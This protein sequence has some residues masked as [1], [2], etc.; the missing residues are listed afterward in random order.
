MDRVDNH[1]RYNDNLIEFA[2][3]YRFRPIV[4][5][6]YQPQSKGRVERSIRYIRSSFLEG[7]SLSSREQLNQE[8][9][10]WC[11]SYAKS[12]PWREDPK[13]TVGEALDEERSSFI[14]RPEMELSLPRIIALNADVHGWVS[15]ESNK[16]SV[17][18]LL[19][20]KSLSLYAYIDKVELWQGQ[21]K[22]ASHRRSWAL[23]TE[24]LDAS[25]R[26]NLPKANSRSRVS[27][28]LAAILADFPRLQELIYLY[29]DQQRDNR[30]L[31]KFVEE[32]RDVHGI[33]LTE[34]LI[35]IVRLE[36]LVDLT[37]IRIKLMEILKSTSAQENLSTII[38][39]NPAARD[40]QIRSHSLDIYDNL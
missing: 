22:V 16:Y 38:P 25:H 18:W 26:E 12:R 3:T 11:L 20:G 32:A 34:N 5:A 29:L 40:L 39:G 13:K 37:A 24:V 17:P 7:R 30:S 6:P 2:K 1:I 23:K 9:L 36:G 27:D 21:T 35:D 15:F 28:R 4:T 31:I 33:K 8:I 14:L 19:A 10:E